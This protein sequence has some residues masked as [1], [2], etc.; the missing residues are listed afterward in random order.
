MATP[1]GVTAVTP[2]RTRRPPT[3]RSMIVEAPYACSAVP[4]RKVLADRSGN[5]AP[6]MDRSRCAIP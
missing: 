2:M 1:G 5:L 6:A 3:V 4:A